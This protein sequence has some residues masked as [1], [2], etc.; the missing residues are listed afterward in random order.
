ML[1]KVKENSL[2]Y[3]DNV[4]IYSVEIQCYECPGSAL[5]MKKFDTARNAASTSFFVIDVVALSK[6]I[7]IFA[8]TR[9]YRTLNTYFPVVTT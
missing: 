5:F 8:V 7:C 3:A 2:T 9:F 1:Y 4:L 6:I